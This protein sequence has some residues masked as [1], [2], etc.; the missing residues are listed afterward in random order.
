[1]TFTT[2]HSVGLRPCLTLLT[3]NTIV[4]GTHK[5]MLQFFGTFRPSDYCSIVEKQRQVNIFYEEHI[6]VQPQ[7]EFGFKTLSFNCY[8][9]TSVSR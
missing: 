2:T 4:H 1:M 7:R 3:L 5:Y 8:F 9:N 6:F